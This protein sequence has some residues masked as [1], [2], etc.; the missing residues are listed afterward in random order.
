MA[1]IHWLSEGA[2]F[3][4]RPE[5][6]ERLSSL[7][8]VPIKLRKLLSKSFSPGSLLKEIIDE[9]IELKTDL[10]QFL[11]K[12]MEKSEQHVEASSG[13]GYW[14][15]HWT[16]NL[17]L[18]DAYLAIYPDRQHN[19]LFSGNDYTFYDSSAMVQPRS[20]KY[21]L[22][23]GYPRQMNSIFED[24]QKAT[25]IAARGDE[26]NWLRTNHGTGSIY[27][28]S[29]FAKLFC[30]AL[31]KFATLD[32]WGMGIEMEAGRPGW[33]DAINGLPGLFG[34]SM[35]ETYA[36][37]RLITLLLSALKAEVSGRLLL[38]VEIINLLHRVVN[39]L[40]RYS[41]AKTDERDRQYWDKVSSAREA[42][43][44]SVRLGLDGLEAE[45][46]FT[47][48]E[49][50]LD[51]FES[52]ID[53]GITRAIELNN[54][55]PPT[56]F[57]Y[58]VEEFE[59]IKDKRG[60]LRLDAQ[61]RPCI[62]VKRFSPA[63]LPLFLEGM[64]RRMKILDA[65]SSENLYEQVKASSLYDRKLKMYKINASLNGWPKDIGR[66][67]AFTPGWL[68]NES[69]WL[70][71]EYKYLLEVLRAGLY[72][73]FFEDIKTSLIPFLNA[74][75]YGRSIL[76]NSSFLVSSAHPDELLHGAGYIARLSGASAEF[77]S[78][79]R[80]MMAGERPFYVQGGQL[81]LA[82]KPVLPSWLFDEDNSISFMFLG[83]TKVIYHNPK[84][85]DTFD[86]QAAIRLIALHDMD[87]KLL[88]LIDGF[89]PA[90]YSERVR[91]GQI[92]KIDVHFA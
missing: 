5:E 91:D 44:S 8:S 82:F 10:Q 36:L 11:A 87:G 26:A 27:R 38:P 86:Q 65:A 83:V 4:V 33:D 29:L 89:I 16:Y 56:F 52:K 85:R 23:D 62:R 69:I 32:P 73:H 37:K 58:R 60:S 2:A 30:L 24:Q 57:S 63:P 81:C 53:K 39:A 20:K 22:M 71:M 6:L 28:T 79:W 40:R 54:G 15:D 14:V 74:K 7:A 35:A 70:H 61:G 76:E 64:V 66:V 12:V 18:I 1:I 59:P 17:D 72:K 47:D 31:I 19:L 21:V 75:I 25:M 48:I 3:T 80:L 13:E 42:F 34:S 50:I 67:C 68:E 84:E 51:A 88:E 46:I 49:K 92:Q 45:L 9:S 77:L 78:M 90:P 41:F 43:R 55:M